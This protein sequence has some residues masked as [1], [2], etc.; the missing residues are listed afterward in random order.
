MR[1][2]RVLVHA[3]LAAVACSM[4]PAAMAPEPPLQLHPRNPHYFV[5][6][7]RPTVLITSGEHYGAVLNLAFDY[8]AYLDE[9]KRNTFNL[10]RT[11]TGTYRE[12]GTSGHG[13]SPLSPGRGP[14]A[15]IAPWAWSGSTGGFEGRKFDLDRWNDAYFDR[16]KAFCR[17]ADAR[18]VIVEL[19]MFSRM[20]DDQRWRSSPLHPDNNLQGEPWR[21]VRFDRFLTLDGPELLARQ[22]AVVRKIVTEL[23]DEPNVYFEIANEP[24][25]RTLRSEYAAA[26]HA[27]HEAIAA[28]IIAAESALPSGRRHLI[29]YNTDYADSEGVGPVPTGVDVVNFH[30]LSRLKPTLAAYEL[31]RP[32]GYDETRW[33]AHDRYPEYLNTMPPAAGRIEAWEFL[34]G[35]GAVY[36]NLN[37][38]YQVDDPAGRRPESEEFKAYLRSLKKF[39]ESFDLPRM[40]QDRT[41]IAS[42]VDPLTDHASVISDPGR[43]SA[44]YLHHSGYGVQRRWYK[45]AERPRRI[46]LSLALPAGTYTVEWIRPADLQLIGTERIQHAGGAVALKQSPEYVSDVALRITATGRE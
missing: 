27:W 5:Y 1:C 9:L 31:N 35:G 18:G 10:T 45:P 42:G 38:A 44:V 43:Q 28:E 46:A 24:A 13:R 41:L 14:S 21:S 7:D 34:V 2:S 33:V 15:F 19:V 26:T 12:E 29:A 30:Y 40:R 8:V 39:L 32:L 36:S 17:A 37:H 22:K 3:A 6:K 11:F 23:R 20:Y 16:L 4:A 25:Q